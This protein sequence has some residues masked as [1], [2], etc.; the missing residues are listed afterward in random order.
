MV[1]RKAAAASDAVLNIVSTII[2]LAILQLGVLPA[3]SGSMGTRNYAMLVTMLSVL[4]LFPGV[5]GNAL[6]NIRLIFSQRYKTLGLVGDYQVLATI[7]V[8]IGGLSTVAIALT[9]G[10]NDIIDLI[11][12]FAVGAGWAAREYYS[13]TFRIDLDYRSVLINNIF[14]SLGYIIGFLL[15]KVLGYW[16]FVYLCG[17]ILSLGH[18]LRH[19]TLYREPFSRT[20]LFKTVSIDWVELICSGFLT[21]SL[22]YADRLLLYPILGDIAVTTYYVSSLAGKVLSTAVSPINSVVLS[23]LARRDERPVRAFQWSLAACFVAC[24]G[25]YFLIQLLAGPVLNLLYPQYAEAAIRYVGIVSASSLIYVL[26]SVITP[27]ILRY[28][29]RKWQIIIN[30]IALVLYALLGFSLS[31]SFG[32]MGFCVATLIANC[33]KLVALLAI[34]YCSK[35]VEHAAS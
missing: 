11:L 20:E 26:I 1:S 28:Y 27:F 29:P 32:L 16:Q 24:V 13:V 9:Y 30:S 12:L 22:N 23:Y 19:S 3:M 10:L 17:Q 34:F 5:L 7:L 15:F 35:P 2:P 8:S 31:R 14:Q 33:A 18:I 4:N 6:N 21:R 25:L